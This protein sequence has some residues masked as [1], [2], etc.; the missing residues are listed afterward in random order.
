MNLTEILDRAAAGELLS[1]AE[2]KFLLELE[3]PEDL[4]EHHE[5][6]AK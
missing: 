3:A 2:L 4:P 6:S 5:T 1:E